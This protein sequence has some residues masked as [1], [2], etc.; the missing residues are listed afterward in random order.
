MSRTAFT[1]YEVILAREGT[2][3][4]KQGATHI[5]MSF[6]QPGF[7]PDRFSKLLERVVETLLFN[8]H[9]SKIVVRAG[10]VRI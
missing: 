7:K 6:C 8:Q 5:D 2:A 4:L 10:V 1:R 3:Q 9:C